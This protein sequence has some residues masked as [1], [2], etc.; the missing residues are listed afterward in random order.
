MREALTS[1][2]KLEPDGE[3]AGP[4]AA[5]GYAYRTEDGALLLSASRRTDAAPLADATLTFG[6]A[7]ATTNTAGF[8][9]A[10]GLTPGTLKVTAAAGASG[11]CPVTISAGLTTAGA[12]DYPNPR[13]AA[14]GYV[15]LCFRA[16]EPYLTVAAVRSDVQSIRG[17]VVSL[18]SGQKAITNSVGRYVL[19]GLEPGVHTLTV[20]VT[21]TGGFASVVIVA[22]NTV[23]AGLLAPRGSIGKVKLSLP[24][25]VTT[26]AVGRTFTLDAVAT[27]PGGTVLSGFSAY[28][29]TTSDASIASVDQFGEVTGL[30]IGSVTISAAAGGV[31][32]AIALDIAPFGAGEPY[33]VAVATVGPPIVDIGDTRQIL[34]K[35]YDK[36]GTLLP[37]WPVAYGSSDE[38]VA[39]VSSSGVVGAVGGG[40]CHVTVSATGTV[41]AALEMQVIE[42]YERLA[43]NPDHLGFV[44][45]GEGVVSIWDRIGGYGGVMDWTAAASEP[46]ISVAPESGQGDAALSVTVDGSGLPAG[47]Y[48]GQVIVDAGAYGK[49]GVVITLDVQEIVII[50]E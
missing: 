4:G 9:L 49:R 37:E 17:A 25:D 16:A 20:S 45:G 30:K 27:T 13:G 1:A 18:D 19:Y 23:T 3:S 5:M 22:E 46:W 7:E 47:Q 44:N 32:G 10:E 43:A 24:S 40:V 48:T 35:V 39:T 50:I 28:T 6:G 36:Y 26:P 33:T 34:A 12:D 8:Y 29:W 11:D 42:T 15:G 14:R 2:G 31:A 21:G 38:T 41:S